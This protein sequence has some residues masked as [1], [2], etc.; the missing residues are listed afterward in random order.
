MFDHVEAGDRMKFFIAAESGTGQTNGRTASVLLPNSPS[1][2][3]RSVNLPTLNEVS[4]VL[5]NF[6][7]E[8][9]GKVVCKLVLG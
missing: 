9:L 2:S 5:K 4:D 8:S 3:M 1:H 7:V 6:A